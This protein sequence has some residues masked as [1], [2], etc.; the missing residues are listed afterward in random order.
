MEE[1]QYQI[2][3]WV[4]VLIYGVSIFVTTVIGSL[5]PIFKEVKKASGLSSFIFSCLYVFSAGV[6]LSSGLVH[7]ST[8]ALNLL[9]KWSG[10]A[11][12]QVLTEEGPK[13]AGGYVFVNGSH[14]NETL[15]ICTGNCMDLP[16]ATFLTGFAIIFVAVIE[17]FSHS[18]EHEEEKD[19]HF[20]LRMT[21]GESGDTKRGIACG[22]IVFLVVLSIPSF[23]EGLGLG[24][25]TVESKDRGIGIFIAIM[26]HQAFEAFALGANF[27]R[28]V[29]NG[30]MPKPL[31]IILMVI[32][33]LLTPA[34]AVV[35][36]LLSDIIKGED[37]FLF[38]GRPCFNYWYFHICRIS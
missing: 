12:P 21:D 34:G 4:L 28:E 8:E 7:L 11:D 20:P 33:S 36:V 38:Q 22:A 14:A 9:V 24:V 3:A 2:N 32:F 13:C 15:F 23:L 29:G 18:D 27:A 37:L 10:C 1:E 6:L 31:A 26:S 5:F 19:D 35:G 25:D 16:I 30:S 17:L